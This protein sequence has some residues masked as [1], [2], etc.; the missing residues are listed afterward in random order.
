VNLQKRFALSLAL[1]TLV[2][3]TAVGAS[4]DTVSKGTFTLPEQAYWG[5][6]LLQPGDYTV[7]IDFRGGGMDTIALRGEGVDTT[8]LAPA[9]YEM[10]SGPGCL[11]LTDANGTYVIRELRDSVSG[12][13][14]RFSVPKV[15]KEAAALGGGTRRPVLVRLSRSGSAAAD[16][17]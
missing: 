5:N 15:A 4:A 9:G 17:Q 12:R 7:V 1:V 10:F 13:A 2:G 3:L 16:A 14:Y 11:K 8:M 6:T